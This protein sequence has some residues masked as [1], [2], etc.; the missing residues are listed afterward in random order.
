MSS[1]I[2]QSTTTAAHSRVVVVVGSGLAGLCASSELVARGVPVHIV[3]RQ[4]K[5]GGN[6]IKASSGINGVPTRFQA[7]GSDT[8]AAFYNDTLRSAGASLSASKTEARQK[9]IAKLTTSSAEAI[10]WLVDEKGI[11]LSHVAQLGGHSHPRTHRG[12]GPSPPGASIVLTLLKQLQASSLVT[13]QTD[14]TVTKILKS[15]GG[16][17]VGVQVSQDGKPEKTI[18]GPVIFTAGGFAGD[19]SGLLA[20]YRPDLEGFPSTNEALPGSQ[21][22][23][24]DLGAHLVDME[25]VQVHPTGFVDPKEPFKR[26]KFLAAELLRGEGGILLRQGRRFIN[27]LRLRKQVT[28]AIVAQQPP[29]DLQPTKQWEIQIMLDEAT[30]AVAKSHVDFYI[31]KGLMRKST[32]SELEHSDATLETIKEY[33]ATVQGKQPDLFGRSSFGHWALQDPRPDSTVYVGTVTPVVHYTMGGAI[34]SPEAE[35]LDGG[36]NPIKGLWAAGESTGGIHGENRL[37][38][39]SLLEC[40][41]FGRVAGRNAA[42]FLGA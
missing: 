18:E 6:S 42:K 2:N 8:V 23:L 9:L 31:W 35:V 33:A 10:N 20:Q 3:E 34:F 37:G 29:N 26:T 11:D 38:G 28:D 24:T 15:D 30:Y 4:Q 40:V 1:S 36:G 7:Q 5:P 19:S 41:V 25:Q 21:A 17:V 13:L 27:E 32:I 39:S 22:L 14:T 16:E 12:A